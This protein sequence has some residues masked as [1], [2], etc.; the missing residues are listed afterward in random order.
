MTPAGCKRGT[1]VLPPVDRDGTGNRAGSRK[2]KPT[3]PRPLAAKKLQQKIP[4]DVLKEF[5]RDYD[6]LVRNIL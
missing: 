6:T 5:A 3:A 2:K 1:S 4:D